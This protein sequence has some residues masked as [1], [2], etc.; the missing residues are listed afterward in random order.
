MLGYSPVKFLKHNVKISSHP[1][2]FIQQLVCCTSAV[3]G[4]SFALW[5]AHHFAIHFLY[6]VL[7]RQ[8]DRFRM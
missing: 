6:A 7:V 4:F 3:F 5:G 8:G 2:E 1:V